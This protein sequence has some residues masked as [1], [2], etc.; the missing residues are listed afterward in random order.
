[1]ACLSS[2]DPVCDELALWLTEQGLSTEL[3]PMELLLR[4]SLNNAIMHGC[5]LDPAR[6]VTCEVQNLENTLRLR[7]KDDGTGFDWQEHLQKEM[8]SDDNESG[9]GIQL[10]R[11]YADSVE[12]N[13]CG[14]QV[15]LV[16]RLRNEEAHTCK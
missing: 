4:E 5:R 2:I 6:Q 16:R 7:I 14:N 9:R 1:M 10:F 15:T 8:V 13:P 11:L 3:F 12:F